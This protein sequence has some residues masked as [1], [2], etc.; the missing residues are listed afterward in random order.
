ME[1]LMADIIMNVPM[2]R[3]GSMP[4][5]VEFYVEVS[6]PG[7]WNHTGGPKCS[8]PVFEQCS[9]VGDKKRRDRSALIDDGRIDELLEEV[10][11]SR[12][13]P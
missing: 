6:Q 8:W 3:G 12:R 2:K 9:F 1:A 7:D 10:L 11:N 13:E 5:R 4:M